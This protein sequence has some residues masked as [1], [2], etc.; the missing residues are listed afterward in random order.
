VVIKKMQI[1]G[2]PTVEVPAGTSAVGTPQ[3]IKKEKN[4]GGYKLQSTFL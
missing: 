4:G 3:M 1:G 2:V